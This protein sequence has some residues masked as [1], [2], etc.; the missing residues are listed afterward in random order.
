LG[1]FALLLPD[2]AHAQFNFTTNNGTITITRYLGGLGS[3]VTIPDTT[4]G[5]AIIVIGPNAFWRIDSMTSVRIPDSVTSIGDSAFLG[6]SSLTNVIMGNSVTNLGYGA[7]YSCSSLAK[8]TIP[9][10]IV[11]IGGAAFLG[12]AGLTTITV[13]N[14]VTNIPGHAFDGCISLTNLTLGSNIV[15]IGEA[16]FSGCSSLASVT[17]PHSVT[18]IGEAAFFDCSSLTNVV[19]GNSVTNIGFQ[20]FSSCDSLV[21]VTMPNSMLDIGGGAFLV[22][23]SLTSVTISKSVT[24]IGEYAFGV[25]YSLTNITVDPLNSVFSSVDGVLFDKNQ[26]TLIQYPGGKPGSYVVPNTVTSIVAFAF[27]D[28]P[29]LTSVTLPKSLA[30]FEDASFGD[31]GSLTNITVDPLNTVYSSVDGVLF[32]KNQTT[33]IQY[34]QGKPGSYIIPNSVAN[35]GFNAFFA[36]SSLSNITIPN[37]VT[38]I[39]AQAFYDCASLSSVTIPDSVT[40][41]GG[42]A[43]YGCSSLTNVT[44]PA[45]VTSIGDQTFRYC[46]NLVAA[47]FQ[48]DAPAIEST[49]WT[50][51]DEDTNVVYYLPGTSGW[52]STYCDRPTAPWTPQVRTSDAAFG[53]RTNQFGFQVNWA[54]GRNAV[55]E[56]STNLNGGN[57]IPLQTNTVVNGSFYFGDPAWNK[58]PARFYRVRSP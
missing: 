54:S 50:V 45:S 28:S 19:M 40:S 57:W 36:C 56:T 3:D 14:S 5:M 26:T 24:T 35:I 52:G 42:L 44:I 13:P 38:N 4:N 49:P 41:I 23:H 39:A 1:L 30:S 2:S 47:Y 21:N 34:P 51:F 17:I 12:C 10:S 29:N 37:S 48:G 11:N 33:L 58:Y 16:A 18:S 20:A 55:V 8:T 43:F 46:S 32:D 27:S 15:S 6:C 22:C 53:V 31:C 25:C 9:N 7:F